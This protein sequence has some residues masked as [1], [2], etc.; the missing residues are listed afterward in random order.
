MSCL[1]RISSGGFGPGLYFD[2]C[3]LLFFLDAYL[4]HRL[5]ICNIELIISLSVFSFS[6]MWLFQTTNLI[7]ST[8]KIPHIHCNIIICDSGKQEFRSALSI[9]P[10]LLQNITFSYCSLDD[11]SFCNILLPL[12]F[13]VLLTK[14]R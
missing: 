12:S 6:A 13:P 4:P 14:Y 1:S 5:S 7:S 11:F 3:S 10:L 2:R 8:L 9:P